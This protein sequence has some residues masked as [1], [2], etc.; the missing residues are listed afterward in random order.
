MTIGTITIT[1]GSGEPSQA[2]YADQ[3]SFAGDASYLTPGMALKDLY[4]AKA[5]DHR[6]PVA[7]I[8]GDCGGYVPVYIPSTGK[9]KVYY[10]NFDASDGP[11][12]EVPDATNLSG[13]TFNLVVL[14]Q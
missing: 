14:S 1:K 12:I 2:T 6:T 4:Q 9:L 10:G 13:V 5:G 8:P 3:I 7:V 11:L